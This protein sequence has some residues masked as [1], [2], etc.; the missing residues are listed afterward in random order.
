MVRAKAVLWQLGAKVGS[1]L[2][3]VWVA[4]VLYLPS[5][6]L[7]AWAWVYLYSNSAEKE[8]QL[9]YTMPCAFHVPL[10]SRKLSLQA[11][12]Q[13]RSHPPAAVTPITAC[14]VPR[15]ASGVHVPCLSTRCSATELVRP[16]RHM[17]LVRT[18]IDEA[19][20]PIVTQVHGLRGYEDQWEQSLPRILRSNGISMDTVDANS[21][22]R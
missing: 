4:L 18:H 21:Y 11:S 22:P 12:K 1:R 8:C 2:Q 17:P 13:P 19:L 14:S 5:T 15:S 7:F 9:I 10:H 3:V 16:S 20:L 6:T